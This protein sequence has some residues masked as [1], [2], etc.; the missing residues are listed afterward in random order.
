MALPSTNLKHMIQ[1]APVQMEGTGF[2]V[3]WFPHL[4]FL[5]ISPFPSLPSKTIYMYAYM[6]IDTYTYI[7]YISTFLF[8]LKINYSWAQNQVEGFYYLN[9]E[10][11]LPW[12]SFVFI[13]WIWFKHLKISSSVYD[14]WYNR[15]ESWE[16]QIKSVVKRLEYRCYG[17][18]VIHVIDH[19]TF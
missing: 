2:I 11:G 10:L 1:N 5:D 13:L 3:N 15:L 14:L 9:L 19:Q 7:I 8:S 12:W 17:R 6:C 4:F 16:N 18:H